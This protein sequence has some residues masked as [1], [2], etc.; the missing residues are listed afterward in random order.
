MHHGQPEG[1][2]E[3]IVL[4]RQDYISTETPAASVAMSVVNPNI[5]KRKSLEDLKKSDSKRVRLESTGI[6]E[7]LS[8]LACSEGISIVQYVSLLL[9]FF[10]IATPGCHNISLIAKRISKAIVLITLTRQFG[11]ARKVYIPSTYLSI[12][13]T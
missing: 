3:R 10:A 6:M 13:R 2:L 1:N 4:N 12:Y 9:Y 8:L 7:A 11:F 5:P